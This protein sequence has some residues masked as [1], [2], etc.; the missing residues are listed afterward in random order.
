MPYFTAQI[1]CCLSVY[2]KKN[3]ELSK[4]IIMLNI[5]PHKK[6]QIIFYRFFSQPLYIIVRSDLS[7]TRTP[8]RPR[9]SLSY[10]MARNCQWLLRRMKNISNKELRLNNLLRQVPPRNTAIST[11][12]ITV[13]LQRPS[14]IQSC[15]N[16]VLC[17]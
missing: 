16:C 3:T 9:C 11:Q 17:T 15:M 13:R 8:H 1:C 7:S 5:S 4:K 12:D 14:P 6:L 2:S 10:H